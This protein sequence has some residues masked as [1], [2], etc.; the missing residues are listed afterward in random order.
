MNVNFWGVVHGVET[1]VPRLLAHGA[2]G[3]IVNTASMAGLVGMRWLGVYCASK[4][5]VVGLTEALH[6][7]LPE[8]GIGVS[9]LCPMIVETNINENS[10]RNRPA[11][12]R[13]PGGA[14]APE[15]AAMSGSVIGPE[16]VARRVVRGIERSDLYIFTHPEQRPILQRRAARQDRMFEPDR[17]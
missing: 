3:H 11:T 9:V 1:F 10:I 5:A 7:E 17:W 14:V 15:G 16:E 2:G 4:F 13:N 8:Q 12:L 6:R